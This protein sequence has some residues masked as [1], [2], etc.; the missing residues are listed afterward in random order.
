[1][2][3]EDGERCQGSEY[4]NADSCR[5]EYCREL[6]HSEGQDAQNKGVGR[7]H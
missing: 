6:G 5:A 2:I 7:K 1:M 4:K 3:D